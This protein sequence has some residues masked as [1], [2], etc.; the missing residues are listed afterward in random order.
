[1]AALSDLLPALYLSEGQRRSKRLPAANL[2]LKRCLPRSLLFTALT[3]FLAAALNLQ[4]V[5]TL[6]PG[7][8]LEVAQLGLF[9][10]TATIDVEH[11][12]IF[13]VSLGAM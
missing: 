11:R 6:S 13:P 8:L 7:A 3:L 12:R 2:T 4:C 9:L 5:A 1:M 10:L